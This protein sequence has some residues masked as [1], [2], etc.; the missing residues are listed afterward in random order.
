[1]CELPPLASHFN[2]GVSV[3]EANAIWKEALYKET[4]RPLSVAA[5]GSVAIRSN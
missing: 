1:V 3:R 4:T 5:K 2:L